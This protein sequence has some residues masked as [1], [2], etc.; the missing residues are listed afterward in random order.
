MRVVPRDDPGSWLVREPTSRVF[1][2]NSIAR[3]E[4]TGP[5]S[6]AQNPFEVS[7]KRQYIIHLYGHIF[8]MPICVYVH[9]EMS[10]FP[11]K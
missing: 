10:F 4:K 1:D 8:F 7:H 11:Q 3:T 2:D 6:F 9:I 5:N